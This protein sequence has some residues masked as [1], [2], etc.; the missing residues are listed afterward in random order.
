MPGDEP[1]K[2]V[3]CE[4]LERVAISVDPEKFFQVGSE[5]PPLEK[6][7]LIKFLRENV[8]VFPWD[9]YEAPSVDLSFICHHLNVNPSIALRKQPPQHLLKEHANAVK[10]EVMKLKKAG[11]IKEV[12]YLEWLANTVVVKKK[13]EKWRVCVDFTDLNKACPKDPF[14]MPRIDQLVDVT[15]GHPRMSFLDAFQGYHLITLAVDDQEKTAFLTLVRNYHYK[16]MPFGLKNTG[17]T[18]QRMMTRMFESQLKKSI[19]AYI[20]GM[21]VKSKVASEH[22]RDLRDIFEILRRHKLRLNA[23][24]CSFGVGSGKFLC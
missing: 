15:T 8:D 11:A 18:H 12:F 16:V 10:D 13:S 17:S 4:D 2:E 6:E 1:T 22:V 3:K 20:D 19:E 21:V 24:K 7:E 5:L 23:S 14:P 9:A